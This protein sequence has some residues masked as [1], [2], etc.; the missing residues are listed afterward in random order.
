MTCGHQ[1]QQLVGDV[2]I[3]YRLAVFIAG[4][5]QQHEHVGASGQRSFGARLGDEFVDHRVETSPVTRELAARTPPSV[6]APHDRRQALQQRAKRD[7]RW[8]HDAKFVQRV[9]ALAE[10]GAHDRVEGQPGHR[11]QRFE[12]L[13]LRPVRR[14]TQHLVFDDALVVL[15][16]LPVEVGQHQLA[17]LEVFLAEQAERRSGSERLTEDL[18]RPF[19]QVEAGAVDVLDEVAVVDDHRLTKDRQ[20]DSERTAVVTAQSRC[21]RILQ[22]RQ[23]EHACDDLRQPQRGRQP[24]RIGGRRCHVAPAS[25]SLA[26]VF[27]V[28]A[29]C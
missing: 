29:G 19:D 11:R 14:F 4:L 16:P 13:A 3:R 10:R 23:E 22:R 24:N 21:D 6:F 9:G 8:Y 7:Q 20:I 28:P 12:L 1:G 27:R 5:Q 17:A 2:P 18:G 25:R 26:A 15:Y